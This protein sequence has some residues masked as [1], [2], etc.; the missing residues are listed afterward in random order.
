MKQAHLI[1]IGRVQGVFYR[2]N[3]QKEAQRLGLSGWVRNRG[4]GSVEAK[5]TGTKEALE[6]FIDWC[7]KGPPAA[8]V[9]K[10]EVSWKES[11]EEGAKGFHIRY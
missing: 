8:S 4:D 7:R 10:V 6:A 2:A 1:I 5:A 9:E 3:A 11:T